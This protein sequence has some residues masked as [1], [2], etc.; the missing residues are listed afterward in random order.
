MHPLPGCALQQ[1]VTTHEVLNAKGMQTSTHEGL[2]GQ[3]VS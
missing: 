2:G 1:M 3:H